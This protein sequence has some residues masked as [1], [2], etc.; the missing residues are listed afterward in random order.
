M[1]ADV[2][3]AAGERRTIYRIVVLSVVL[4]FPA[5]LGLVFPPATFIWLF[6]G[7]VPDMTFGTTWMFMPTLAI[8]YLA[9]STVLWVLIRKHATR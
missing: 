3:K 6:L 9:C 1:N 4:A 7:A 2:E 8:L 5:A